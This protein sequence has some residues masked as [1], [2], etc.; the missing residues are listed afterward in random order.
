MIKAVLFD[1]DGTLL[2]R[3][4]SIVQFARWQYEQR[5][6]LQQIAKEDYV[7]LFV[8]L[9][10]NG[11]VWKDEVYWQLIERY[12]FAGVGG[13]EL[14]QE[15]VDN[16]ARFAVG[17]PNMHE[18]LGSLRQEGYVL[19]MITNGRSPFQEN[20]VEALNIHRYFS[21]I[22]V[23]EA[24]GMRKPEARIFV[25]ALRRLDVMP[26]DAVFVGDSLESDITGAQNMGMKTIWRA[27]GKD[28]FLNASCTSSN[29]DAVCG[30]LSALLDIISRL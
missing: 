17:F 22:L 30:D 2:D 19:G 6:V 18:V 25:E 16:F 12:G 10:D 11:H 28:G 1:L 3:D 23:S 29:A 14:L 20:A 26:K 27:C 9:D 24:V 21:S 7:R 5:E 8:K 13:D 15:Y 4:T